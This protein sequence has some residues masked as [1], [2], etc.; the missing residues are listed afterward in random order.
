M[1]IVGYGKLQ[2]LEQSYEVMQLAAMCHVICYLKHNDSD[3][4]VANS[5]YEPAEGQLSDQCSR[6][7]LLD[8]F[9]VLEYSG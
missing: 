3:Y 2:L 6:P 8:Q 5:N 1:V 4:C 9:K 7:L